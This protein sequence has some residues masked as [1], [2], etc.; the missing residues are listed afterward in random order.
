MKVTE[1][2]SDDVSKIS[3]NTT[4]Q[5]HFNGNTDTW[6]NICSRAAL[7]I[8]N[9]PKKNFN[10]TI[11]DWNLDRLATANNRLANNF[12]IYTI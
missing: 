4:L 3:L 7:K 5:K 11:F 2:S 9:I 8:Q 6:L 10:W 1:V 12:V